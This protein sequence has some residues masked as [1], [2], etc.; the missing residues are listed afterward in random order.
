V[1][2][3]GFLYSMF[4]WSA[5]IAIATIPL[6]TPFTAYVARITYRKHKNMAWQSPRVQ[7][8][9]LHIGCD[10][11]LAKARDARIGAMREVLMAVK[12]VKV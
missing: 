7:I 9:I 2:S 12:V 10:K 3:G 4:S 11:D 1:L 5:L 8:W 6:M